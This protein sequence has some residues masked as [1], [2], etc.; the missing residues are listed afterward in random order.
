MAGTSP[1]SAELQCFFPPEVDP[2]ELTPR[3]DRKKTCDMWRVVSRETQVLFLR[4][5]WMEGAAPL[6]IPIACEDGEPKV[7]AIKAQ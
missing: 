7:V 1:L 3:L 6:Q 2:C 4:F 5:W